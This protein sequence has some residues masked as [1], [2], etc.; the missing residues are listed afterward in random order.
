MNMLEQTPLT[1]VGHRYRLLDEVGSGGMGRVYR[2]YDRLKGQDVAL[3]RVLTP[4]EKLLTGAS[5]AGSRPGST[6]TMRVALAEEFQMLSSLH[7]PNIITVLDYGF[8]TERQPYFTM[9]LLPSAKTIL[10]AGTDKPF[11]YQ[12]NL[13][14]QILR[15]LHYLHRRGILHRDLKPSNVLV[16]G[17]DVKLLDFG[18]S[19]TFAQ[20]RLIEGMWG[21]LEY[22][23]PEVVRGFPAG[24]AADLYSLGVITYQMIV[25]R[26]PFDTDSITKLVNQ[27]LGEQPDIAALKLDPPL[28]EVISRLLDKEPKN[29]YASAAE[30]LDALAQASGQPLT[31]ESKATR[32]SFLQAAEF[33]GRTNE[34]ARLSHKLSEASS[35][36]NGSLNGAS[37]GGVILVGGESGVGKSRLLD[38][39]R[40][41]ALVNEVAV[42]RGQAVCETSVPYQL[43]GDAMRWMALLAD[44]TDDEAAILKSVIPDIGSLLERRIGDPPELDPRAMH[45]RLLGIVT[46]VLKRAGRPVL[47]ILEDLHWIDDISLEMLAHLSSQIASL[48]VLIVGSYRDDERPDLPKALPSVETIRLSRLSEAEIAALS[49]A[50]LGAAAGQSDITEWLHR[51]T[52]GNAFFLV[53]VIRALAEEAGQLGRIGATTL[54]VQVF[55]GGIQQVIQ[56]RLA[57]VPPEDKPLLLIAA[58]AGRQLDLA[59][60]RAADPK[61]DLDIWLTVCSN[62]AI[63]ERQNE[64]WRFAHDK[65]RDGV[66]TSLSEDERKAL[67]RRVAEAIEKAYTNAASQAAA[68]TYQWSMAGDSEKE[69]IYALVAGD[70]AARLYASSDARSYYSRA[71]AAFA[72]LPMSK[73]YRR[74]R[75]E[76][77]I[78]LTT[79]SWTAYNVEQ[80]LANLKEAEPLAQELAEEDGNEGRLR[81][82][83]V[84]YWIGRCNYLM[85]QNREAIGYYR[86]VLGVAQEFGD[87]ELLA[88]PSSFI[89]Q[90]MVVQGHY[91]RGAPL[92]ARA[93]PLLAKSG[94]WPEWIRANGFLGVTMAAR[95]QYIAGMA[96]ASWGVARARE[97]NFMAGVGIGAIYLAVTHIFGG[98]LTAAMETTETII[99]TAQQAGE[100]LLTYL[101]YGLQAVVLERQGQYERAAEQ[102]AQSSLVGKELGARLILSDWFAAANAHILVGQGKYDEA[103][104]VAQEIIQVA[105]QSGAIYP[106]GLAE[107]AWGKALAAQNQREEAVTHLTTSLQL[108]DSGE[109]VLEGARTHL[110]WGK[111]AAQWGQVD[112]ARG[113]LQKAAACFEESGL[114]DE[115]AQASAALTNLA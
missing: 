102:M 16:I 104:R 12:I 3:K 33:V 57:L 86:Q 79:Q 97:M 14:A 114:A 111:L 63:I 113:H 25:G 68:L 47:M 85:G 109:A 55:T 77:V 58:A 31:L 89:G 51:E 73:E 87:E 81:L 96:Q 56:R 20:A 75:V 71:L 9:E 74:L 100:R 2:A 101:G 18:L 80:T 91:G 115:M 40:T 45:E 107:R 28:A 46:D 69:M 22:M 4:A 93:E 65:M 11:T 32:E 103:I 92:L 5:Q 21:T 82:A 72:A 62:L 112:A 39:L 7:H 105:Q 35:V 19:V 60:L 84:H 6:R 29:R 64:Q 49:A 1:T 37:K 27:I 52:E 110:V 108:L 48:P 36:I 53:E 95:G 66:L 42:L 41:W 106:S 88:M 99:Q 44:L 50:M 15:A 59:V 24:I 26:H 38:E 8:D 98:N 70:A 10:G 90:A 76:T 23:A 61:L 94:N 78:K 17:D 83:R 30:V 34:M 67:H 43:W 13:L 54:P